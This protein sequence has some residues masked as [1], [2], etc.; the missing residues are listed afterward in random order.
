MPD[1][2]TPE[3]VDK[4]QRIF[5]TWDSSGD[6]EISKS[7][8]RIALVKLGMKAPDVDK[9]F[10]AMDFNKDGRITFHEFVRWLKIGGTEAT[11]VDPTNKTSSPEVA[12][13]KIWDVL[14]EKK[15][16]VMKDEKGKET[17]MKDKDLFSFIDANG[18]GEIGISEFISGLRHLQVNG[19]YP[20]AEHEYSDALLHE[21]FDLIDTAKKKY[22]KMTGKKEDVK[23]HA[24]TWKEFKMFLEN[25]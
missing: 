22:N 8:L 7:E 4:L 23:D 5:A 20:I 1:Y 11:I 12:A 9:I 17:T 14:M 19:I 6:G 15:E 24:L 13:E 16:E 21:V 10:G 3:N 25:K 18:N 2:K